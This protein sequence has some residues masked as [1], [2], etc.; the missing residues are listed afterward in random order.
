MSCR[1]T[2]AS[3]AQLGRILAKFRTPLY[4]SGRANTAVMQY[5]S[6]RLLGLEAPGSPRLVQQVSDKALPHEGIINIRHLSPGIVNHLVCRGLSQPISDI[7]KGATPSVS[8]FGGNRE[9]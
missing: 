4:R 7:P 2:H 8:Q 5:T 6:N 3:A 1:R 9:I